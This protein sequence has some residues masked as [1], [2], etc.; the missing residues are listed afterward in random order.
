MAQS[1]PDLPLLKIFRYLGLVDLTR[2]RAVS[3]RWKALIDSCVKIDELVVCS[4]PYPDPQNWW[5]INKTVYSNA[6]LKLNLLDSTDF[7]NFNRKIVHLHPLSSLKRLRV[8]E[9]QSPICDEHEVN[10]LFSS[11]INFAALEHLEIE[12]NFDWCQM[13]CSLVH[14]NVKVLSLSRL[15]KSPQIYVQIDCPR[16]EVL[17]CF[18]P[19]DQFTIKHPETIKQLDDYLF[20]N[21]YKKSHASLSDLEAFANLEIYSCSVYGLLNEVN[22]WNLPKLKELRLRC[23]DRSQFTVSIL[24]DLIAKKDRLGPERGNPKMYINNKECGAN[25]EE[26]HP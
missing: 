12:L 7:L 16:L 23:P 20:R 25:L 22:P 19:F 13:R 11:L 2:A 6:A 26:T 8:F 17:H 1:L 18:A 24:T 5:H 9:P 15:C 21:V 3:R 10:R 4:H 14:P